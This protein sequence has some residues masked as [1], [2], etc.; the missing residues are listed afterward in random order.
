MNRKRKDLPMSL[1]NFIVGLLIASTVMLST[2]FGQLYDD[3]LVIINKNSPISDSIG[4]YFAQARNI[5]AINVARL[6]LPTA[7]TIDSI[8]FDTLRARV[9]RYILN[10][11]LQDKINYIVT[12]KGVPLRVNRGNTFH[13]Q[14]PSASVES[15]LSLILGPYSDYIGQAGAVLSPYHGANTRFSRASYGFYLVTRLDGYTYQDVKAMIDKA[16]QPNEIPAE[17]TFVFDQ[18]PDWTPFL[19]TLN[20]NIVRA[21]EIL[22]KRGFSSLL[23][24]SHIYQTTRSN[25][26]GYV[27]WGSND[28][29]DELYTENAKPKNRWLPGAIAETYVSTSAR[30]FRSPLTYGQSA[31]ADLI[32]E[33][34]TGAKGYV[35]E[36]FASAMANVAILFDRYTAGYN[37]A[38]SFAMASMKN[39]SWMDV[40]VGDP[41]ARLNPK[42]TIVNAVTASFGED[43]NSVEL[44]WMTTMEERNVGFA[45]ERLDPPRGKQPS[46]WRQVGFVNGAGTTTEPQQYFY[47]DTHLRPGTYQYRVKSID[48]LGG[49]LFSESVSIKVGNRPAAA[50]QENVGD[51]ATLLPEAIQLANY[52]NP[53][54]PT[55]NVHFTLPVSGFITLKVYNMLGQEVVTLIEGTMNEG[56][57]S[58]QFDASNLASGNYIYRLQAAETVVT[59]KMALLK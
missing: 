13:T 40:V 18:D 26:I 23:D 55:T 43:V 46:S 30:S 37:L 2:A 48:S 45:I 35:Y 42:R 27:S 50:M 53:F 44:R 54:N 51:A 57:H 49:V 47:R 15:E 59:E 29:Y 7:E 20:T 34:I 36:P 5:P 22:T 17:G 28:H 12:T 52:P 19:G 33:G 38:E 14:S 3:V 1:R 24:S 41:K 11:N 32:A 39:L 6:P 25:V 10:N 8:K 4:T 21:H 16:A 58:V 56:S 9:E 31:I